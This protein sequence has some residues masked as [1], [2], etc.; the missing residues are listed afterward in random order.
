MKWTAYHHLPWNFCLHVQNKNRAN[1]NC[2]R[3]LILLSVPNSLCVQCPNPMRDFVQPEIER[4]SF[5]FKLKLRG[6]Q[7]LQNCLP[8]IITCRL[9]K[10]NLKKCLLRYMTKMTKSMKNVRLTHESRKMKIGTQ[11]LICTETHFFK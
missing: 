7:K 9:G 6:I 5:Y 8:K 4:N 2:L 3:T 1:E 11:A 10:N